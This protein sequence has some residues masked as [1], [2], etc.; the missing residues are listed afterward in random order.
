MIIFK[1]NF[2]QNSKNKF[3][4]EI[5]ENPR[6]SQPENPRG[7]IVAGPESSKATEE[8]QNILS[9][10]GE[11]QADNRYK[12][13]F[14]ST[15]D[16]KKYG[17]H[18]MFAAPKIEIEICSSNHKP[19]ENVEIGKKYETFLKNG[20]YYYTHNPSQRAYIYSTDV[21]GVTE[22]LPPTIRRGKAN[23]PEVFLDERKTDDNSRGGQIDVIRAGKTYKGNKRAAE[24]SDYQT[25]ITAGP[26]I[27]TNLRSQKEES[28]IEVKT[29]LLALENEMTS[30]NMKS[31]LKLKGVINSTGGRKFE[32]TLLQDIKNLEKIINTTYIE[33]VISPFN[34]SNNGSQNRP[35]P[36]TYKTTLKDGKYRYENNP[37]IPVR[38]MS[39]DKI[40]TRE[41]L[42]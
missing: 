23:N 41:K 9:K 10:C 4:F 21:A 27:L 24:N 20:K 22:G 35:K 40:I 19:E 15:E 3:L 6:I 29:G 28:T 37:E 34:A 2:L 38:L 12:I 7:Q 5:A 39:G 32:Y 31:Y 26:K 8:R 36:G 13:I 11:L 30:E 17:L 1:D 25:N 42:F 18:D 33:I 16:E 14:L